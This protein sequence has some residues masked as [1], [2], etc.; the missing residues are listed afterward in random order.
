MKKKT[1]LLLC[2]AALVL[3]AV[4]FWLDS[5]RYVCRQ[6]LPG[7]EKYFSETDESAADTPFISDERRDRLF[8]RLIRRALPSFREPVAVEIRDCHPA[9]YEGKQIMWYML[10]FRDSDGFVTIF[11]V[12][13]YPRW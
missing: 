9:M 5:A 7:E 1:V 10:R 6:T 11:D 3:L 4:Y 8:A 12:I 13:L 2:A